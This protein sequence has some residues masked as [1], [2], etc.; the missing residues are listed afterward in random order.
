[1]F[2]LFRIATK[3][4]Y[5]PKLRKHW[6]HS[7]DIYIYI[8]IYIYTHTR[9]FIKN[10]RQLLW[11]LI[12]KNH[13]VFSFNLSP[14]C[15]LIYIKYSEFFWIYRKNLIVFPVVLLFKLHFQEHSAVVVNAWSLPAC[16]PSFLTLPSIFPSTLLS[17]PLSLFLPRSLG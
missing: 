6:I 4:H 10:L 8:Y 1:M 2:F 3:I 9:K 7:S 13:V 12:A 16:D 15:T 5:D 11:W 17:L 14:I